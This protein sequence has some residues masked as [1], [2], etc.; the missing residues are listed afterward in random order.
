MLKSWS[1]NHMIRFGYLLSNVLNK[2][3]GVAQ[4]FTGWVQT[5]TILQYSLMIQTSEQKTML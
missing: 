3:T 5:R 4:W 1:G 2:A